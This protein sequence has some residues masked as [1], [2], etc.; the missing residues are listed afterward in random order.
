[1][2][3]R[4]DS[5][6]RTWLDMVKRS[7]YAWGYIKAP[8]ALRLRV[9]SVGRRPLSIGRLPVISN[10]GRMIFGDRIRL[11]AHV[12]RSSFST[13]PAGLLEVGSDVFINQGVHIHSENR[14]FIGSRV[15]IGDGVRIYDT[16]FHAVAPGASIRTQGVTIGDDVWIGVNAIILP[17]AS[18]ER[19]AVIGAGCVVSFPVTRGQVLVP[20]SP[21][22]KKTIVIP[23]DYR[24]RG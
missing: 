7:R 6:R 2:N 20:P 15:D 16:N 14:V 9:D 13:G 22:V 23:D 19:G 1:M 12:A 24:R 21:V 4:G 3:S 10:R 18:I 11:R 17:G 8:L 5:L